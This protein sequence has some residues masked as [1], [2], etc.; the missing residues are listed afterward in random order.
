MGVKRGLGKGLD[1][2][3]DSHNGTEEERKDFVQL[4][5]SII[6]PNRDQPRKDFDEEQLQALSDSIIEHG[7]IQPIIVTPSNGG[8]YRI[9]AGER[10][11]RAAKMAGI[12]NIPAIVRVCEK[13]EEA[14]IAMIENL[15]RE[16]L[17]ACEEAEGYLYL[18]ESFGMTQEQVG[19]RIGKSR[20]AV[21]NSVRLLSL[22]QN[23]LSMIREGLI[24][25]GHA[26]AL[27]SLESE[28]EQQEL[29]ERIINESISVREVEK[30]VSTKKKKQKQK[31][32]TNKLPEILELERIIS[33][34][35]QTK[36]RITTG[37]KKGKIEIE[38]YGNED[39]CRILEMLG[40][41]VNP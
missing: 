30:T 38:F 3:F 24:S 23:I 5:T 32:E 26:R 25:G 39:L 8:F 35:L 20:S 13:K 19:Q 14:E 33:S 29:A 41:N 7:M 36:V 31:I 27:L 12:K 16:D 22:P 6:E 10:R 40:Q 15:Q 18:I 34:N 17:N 9:I 4:K 2:L 28:K 21:A 1:A 37:V 11:W